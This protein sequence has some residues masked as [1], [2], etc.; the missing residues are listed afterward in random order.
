MLLG[1]LQ[2]SKTERKI[3]APS[4]NSLN[5]DWWNS[6]GTGGEGTGLAPSVGTLGL[7]PPGSAPAALAVTLAVTVVLSFGSGL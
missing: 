7:G 3:H 4:V 6:V 1:A 2:K 5:Q